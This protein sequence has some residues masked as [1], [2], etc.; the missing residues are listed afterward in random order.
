M[1]N[2]ERVRTDHPGRFYIPTREVYQQA[3][4]GIKKVVEGGASLVIAEREI[5]PPKDPLLM[6]TF[7]R[8]LGTLEDYLNPQGE[9]ERFH[10]HQLP[11]GNLIVY[12]RGMTAEEAYLHLPDAFEKAPKG[13]L[14][15]IILTK[16]KDRQFKAKM[17]GMRAE[18]PRFLRYDLEIL[19]ASSEERDIPSNLMERILREAYSLG[20]SRPYKRII[21]IKKFEEL[22]GIPSTFP[23]NG[24]YTLRPEEDSSPLPSLSFL[25]R[26]K[27]FLP[28]NWP[29]NYYLPRDPVLGIMPREEAQAIAL[30]AHLLN[31]NPDLETIIITGS[32]GSGKTLLAL[33]AAFA[34]IIP[35]WDALRRA[36]AVHATTVSQ[37]EREYLRF[38]KIT[39]IKPNILMG[40]VK[41][42][43]ALP[44]TLEDKLGP[45]IQS[46][47]DAYNLLGSVRGGRPLS[48]ISFIYH[49]LD[50]RN[51]ELEKR[52]GKYEKAL[53]EAGFDL[54]YLGLPSMREPLLEI[55][56]TGYVRG[57]TF[58]SRIIPSL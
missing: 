45:Y 48:S 19:G 25:F 4:E 50:W 44:G 51:F 18:S 49:Y 42:I 58:S 8:T 34:Q 1:T 24:I 32:H 31:P 20:S 13:M 55:A 3:G 57:R 7:E 17:A 21:P 33:A 2:E 56:F 5:V 15:R 46:Y 40:G 14:E 16:K 26:E 41:D 28:L 9:R 39:L 12:A 38:K 54:E 43:G 35:D 53:R 11:R 52:V 22:I 47:V 36:R 37:G 10:L 30:Y 27:G 6:I 23:L 29:Q